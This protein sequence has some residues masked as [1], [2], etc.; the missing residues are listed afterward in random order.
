MKRVRFEA[1]KN[2]PFC[3]HCRYHRDRHM[4]FNNELFCLISDMKACE[5]HEEYNDS[6][7]LCFKSNYDPGTVSGGL[8]FDAGKPRVDLLPPDALLELGKV[9]E[10]GAKKYAERN[11]EEGMKWSKVLGPLLRHLF[12]WMLRIERDEESGQRHIAHVAWNA[13]ALLTYELRRVGEDDRPRVPAV[14]QDLPLGPAV[15]DNER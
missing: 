10:Y 11:W 8:R 14:G 9:Y 3:A 6:C 2:D 5:G 12:E 4:R 15:K 7:E 1:K 13:L